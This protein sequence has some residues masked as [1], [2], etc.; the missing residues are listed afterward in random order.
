M[1]SE[2]CIRDSP[3]DLSVHPCSNRVG[4]VQ[5]HWPVGS[6]PQFVEYNNFVL[7]Q[8]DAESWGLMEGRRSHTPWMTASVPVTSTMPLGPPV[9]N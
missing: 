8:L 5:D 6:E 1:G 3:T 4:M 9:G 7:L 2:M